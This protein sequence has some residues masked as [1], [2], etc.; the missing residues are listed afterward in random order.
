MRIM[1]LCDA[2]YSCVACEPN[3]SFMFN[4]TYYQR[5]YFSMFGFI[6]RVVCHE[7]AFVI[8]HRLHTECVCVCVCLNHDCFS[9]TLPYLCSETCDLRCQKVLR[10]LVRFWKKPLAPKTN[11]TL[12]FVIHQPVIMNRPRFH[13][14]LL[15]IKPQAKSF[16]TCLSTAL[17]F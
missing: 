12:L 16:Y 6:R 7:I 3:C 11:V 15:E 14:Q 5:C 2:K 9:H 13:N 17:H 8:P 4:Q 1:C 10:D